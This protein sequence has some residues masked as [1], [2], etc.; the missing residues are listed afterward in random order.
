[1]G[2]VA[3]GEATNS[4]IFVRKPKGRDHLG[5]LG[6]DRIILEWIL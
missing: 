6:V 5:D 3:D 1:V 4:H 2:H